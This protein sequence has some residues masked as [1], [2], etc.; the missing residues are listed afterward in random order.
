MIQ[1]LVDNREVEVADEEVDGRIEEMVQGMEERAAE[2]RA[3]FA[4]EEDRQNLRAQMAEEKVLEAVLEKLSTKPGRTLA[5]R[6]PL[7]EPPG[8][9]EDEA[10]QQGTPSESAEPAVTEPDDSEQDDGA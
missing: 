3:S 7:V 9:D 2:V 8:Q 5:L 6:D 10:A 4:K 1:N